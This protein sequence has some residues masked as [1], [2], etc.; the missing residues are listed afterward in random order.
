MERIEALLHRPSP[1]VSEALEVLGLSWP[2][3]IL[4]VKKAYRRLTRQ[5]HPDMGGSDV[6][7]YRVSEAYEE[8]VAIT[9][10]EA[11]ARI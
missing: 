5:V 6:E 8:M 2:C 10:K 7:F 1:V 11:H 4:D 9:S 3:T